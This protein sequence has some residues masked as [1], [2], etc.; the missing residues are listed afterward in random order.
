MNL[1]KGK[2]VVD[3]VTAV[4]TDT[5]EIMTEKA[6]EG[7]ATE[8]FDE[9]MTLLGAKGYCTELIGATLKNAGKADEV[10]LKVIQSETKKA[11][12]E[13]EKIYNKSNRGTYH[14]QI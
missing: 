9:I 6:H 12:K 1:Y 2:L 8:L 10:Q 5:E 14:I 13:V 7:F 4:E 3:I 11:M